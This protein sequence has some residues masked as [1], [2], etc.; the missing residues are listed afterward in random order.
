MGAHA[1]TRG[2]RDEMETVGPELSLVGLGVD[3]SRG[4]SGL[5]ERQWS[6]AGGRT[7]QVPVAGARRCGAQCVAR[8]ERAAAPTGRRALHGQHAPS[9]RRG[10]PHGK[11]RKSFLENGLDCHVVRS[12]EGLVHSRRIAAELGPLFEGGSVPILVLYP[13]GSFVAANEVALRQYGYTLEEILERRI[14]D[15]LCDAF[16]VDGELASITAQEPSRALDRRR[17]RRKDGSLLWVLPSVRRMTIGGE[18]YVV[19]VPQDVTAVALLETRAKKEQERAEDLWHAASERLADGIAIIDRDY[20]IL[21]LNNAMLALLRAT[22][23]DVVGKTCRE[24]FPAC[25]LEDPCEHRIAAAQQKR[26]VRELRSPRTGRPIQIDILPSPP[27][28]DHFAFIHVAHDP[29]EERAMRSELIS[30]DRLATIGRLAAGVAHEVNN[31]AAAVTVN[32]GL[33]RQRLAAWAAR[34][35][36][37]RPM[38]DESIE[39]MTRIRDIVH[40]L[41]GFAR[42]RSTEK[43]DMAEL[44]NSAVRM[45]AHATRG[46]ARVE[47]RLERDVWATARRARIAQ[48]VLN[49]LINSAEAIPHGDQGAHT[50][51]VR[52]FKDGE[53]ACIEVS[54]TGPGVPPE[55][56]ERI[57][58]PFFTTRESSGGTGI[59]LW[60]AR[61]II[62]EEG[63]AIALCRGALPGATFRVSLPCV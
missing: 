46:H 38:L 60:L 43:V 21:R 30:A 8:S 4:L 61:E 23:A 53:R 6:Q 52:T 32:L 55:L 33:L 24:V 19:S 36:D 57:F 1:E 49:L 41:K 45:A 12:E 62:E 3:P 11:T 47:Q 39:A 34:P 5:A 59:G 17:H 48:V 18:A 16:D 54:D 37:I 27:G 13:G 20:R 22:E 63:G 10:R 14:H 7:V 25:G 50:I 29:T 44:A 2:A 31:P 28:S 42:E 40:D 51:L 9:G 58:E 35:S 15:L 56:A 26:L